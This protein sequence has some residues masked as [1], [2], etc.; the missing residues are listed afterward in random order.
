MK[1]DQFVPG[2]LIRLRNNRIHRD[3]GALLWHDPASG[4]CGEVSVDELLLVIA[5]PRSWSFAIEK[6]EYAGVGIEV[7]TKAGKMVIPEWRFRSFV[8]AR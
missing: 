5:P 1:R 3:H 2:T 4:E 6:H 7:L 8:V